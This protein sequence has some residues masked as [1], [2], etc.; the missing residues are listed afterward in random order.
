METSNN[1]ALPNY[2]R[3]SLLFGVLVALALII[4]GRMLVPATSLLNSPL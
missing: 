4:A 2:L 1:P 3:R